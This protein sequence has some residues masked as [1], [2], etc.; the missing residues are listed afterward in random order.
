MAKS[1]RIE[2]LNETIKEVLSELVLNQIKDPRV[3]LVTI[4]AVRVS[5]DLSVAKVHYSVM[6]DEAARSD[7]HKGLVSAR[8]FM[9]KAIGSE[10]RVR[11][12]PELRFV[13]DDSLDRSMAIEDAL[14]RAETPSDDDE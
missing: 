7:T 9:R 14:R 2:R 13:Y 6:G 8:G 5:G 12:A 3:G 10:L 1:Y 11:N 4:T